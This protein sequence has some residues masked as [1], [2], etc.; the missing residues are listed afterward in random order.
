MY[1]NI[2]NNHIYIRID[3]IVAISG[4]KQHYGKFSVLALSISI[5]LKFLKLSMNHFYN[6]TNRKAVRYSIFGEKESADF[7]CKRETFDILKLKRDNKNPFSQWQTGIRSGNIGCS[8]PGSGLLG[9][10]FLLALENWKEKIPLLPEPQGMLRLSCW[11]N[12]AYPH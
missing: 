12:L 7:V 11:K 5:L 6:Q 9:K 4:N 8:G 10:S 3:I 1:I 2:Y